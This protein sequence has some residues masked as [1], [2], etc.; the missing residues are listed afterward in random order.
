MVPQVR[1]VTWW[2]IRL[3][4]LALLAQGALLMGGWRMYVM[5]GLL[6]ITTLVAVLFTAE[7]VIDLRMRH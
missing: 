4:C 7:V 6:C 2:F 3:V 5:A 1:M